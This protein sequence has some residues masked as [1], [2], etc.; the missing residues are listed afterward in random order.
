[1]GTLRPDKKTLSLQ[2]SLTDLHYS[3]PITPKIAILGVLF[4]NELVTFTY[5]KKKIAIS[6][7]MEHRLS[8]L[9]QI[10]FILAILFTVN[11]TNKKYSLFTD[12]CS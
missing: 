12:S 5:N 4:I 2:I 10:I 9:D 8:P 11:Y 6:K 3:G 1:M 7:R